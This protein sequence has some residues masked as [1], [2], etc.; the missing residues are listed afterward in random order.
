MNTDHHPSPICTTHF[1]SSTKC[2]KVI[3]KYVN[4]KQTQ[5]DPF[6]LLPFTV[7]YSDE[8]SRSLNEADKWTLT[9]KFYENDTL[10]VT[11]QFHAEGWN[12]KGCNVSSD[13]MKG[14]HFPSDL[15]KGWFPFSWKM[16]GW[17][18][19]FIKYEGTTPSFQ[20]FIR[21]V[22]LQNFINKVDSNAC[23]KL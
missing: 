9:H 6:H 10:F 12:L 15:M 2:K 20:F 23:S 11:L 5:H 22:V 21:K 8:R 4:K 7:R 1:F 16:K 18:H 17:N 13:F 19:P 3:F 14:R